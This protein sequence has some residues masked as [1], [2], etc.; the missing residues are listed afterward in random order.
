MVAFTTAAA[1]HLPQAL[2]KSENFNGT[3]ETW[4]ERAP[5]LPPQLK[6]REAV[7]RLLQEN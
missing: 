4:K 3:L 6:I 2:Q 1:S 7:T 5:N